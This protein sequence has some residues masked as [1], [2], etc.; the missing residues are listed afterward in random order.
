MKIKK[1]D[2]V[3]MVK[4][5]IASLK[6]ETTVSINKD[7]MAK[8]HNDKEIVLTDPDGK[9]HKIV[10]KEDVSL[11]ANIK[12]FMSKLTSALKDKGL[13]R[14]R[15]T[16]ILGG[17]IDSLGIDP[18]QLMMMVKKAKKHNMSRGLP[19][20]EVNEDKMSAEQMKF[21]KPIFQAAAKKGGFK[22][23]KIYMSFRPQAEINVFS[24]GKDS[25]SILSVWGQALTKKAAMDIKK[26]VEK[27]DTDMLMGEKSYR[28]KITVK[29]DT[30][31]LD[32][33]DA[34]VFAGV[35]YDDDEYDRLFRSR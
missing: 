30:E 4:E 17:V 24:Y 25:G 14:K 27:S 31:Y 35:K 8:L 19:E 1:S 9:E 5:E 13:N 28:P 32:L 23:K 34:A 22:I 7:Q 3:N 10:F 29:P 2:I 6:N 11:P 20:N 26:I 15:Q 33:H 21:A 12:R 18:S 16:A